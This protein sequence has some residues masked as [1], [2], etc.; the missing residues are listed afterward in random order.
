MLNK[1]RNCR[2]NHSKHY[3]RFCEDKDSNH[4]AIDCPETKWL[5]HSTLAQNLEGDDGIGEIGLRPFNNNNRFGTGIYFAEQKFAKE[6]NDTRNQVEAVLLSCKVWLGK[7]KEYNNNEDREG[8]W[9]NDFDS[10]TAIH[11]P[12]NNRTSTSFT[13]W[14][15]KN[16]R[17]CKIYAIT[18]KGTE[19][20]MMDYARDKDI[21]NK[22]KA[23]D[24]P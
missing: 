20:R 2:E 7:C 12:W 18:Y 10:C 5:F 11:P 6:L 1:A 23:G 22:I 13:E 19:I 24:Y 4:L 17:K 16:P 9:A 15:I 14:V 3:C 8:T 21:L